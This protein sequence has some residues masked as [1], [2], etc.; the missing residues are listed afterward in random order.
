[1][2]LL[3][4]RYRWSVAVTDI[5]ILSAAETGQPSFAP[6]AALRKAASSI[7][8][9]VPFTS[10]ALER[11]S[12]PPPF[13][14]P[15]STTQLV[16]SHVEGWPPCASACDSAIEKQLACAA[17]SSSSG[18]VVLPPAP[19]S[20]RAFQESPAS[21]NVPL[22]ALVLPLPDMRSP[23]HCAVARLCM[24]GPFGE[25][26]EADVAAARGRRKRAGPARPG[27]RHG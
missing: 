25:G 12:N 4:P 19:L 20:V 2:R 3:C 24:R 6:S 23:S 18:V 1:M 14:G 27:L 9:T 11:T 22:A 16:S 10:S 15:N 8:G 21:R 7:P 17:A 26:V 5:G 13:L